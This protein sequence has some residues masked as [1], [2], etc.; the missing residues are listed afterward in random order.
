MACTSSLH[1]ASFEEHSPQDE[2]EEYYHLLSCRLSVLQIIPTDTDQK[3]M[4]GEI[5]QNYNITI[6]KD[7]VK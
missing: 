5:K 6:P 3:M 1:P 7:K 4:M 2:K